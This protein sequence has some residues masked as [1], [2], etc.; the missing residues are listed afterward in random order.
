MNE[1]TKIYLIALYCI[2]GVGDK[3]I[4]S[5]IERYSSIENIFLDD[6]S[7][8][9]NI[10]KTAVARNRNYTF[11]K[12]EILDKAN[13]I[14]EDSKKRNIEIISIFDKDYPFNLK[15]IDNPPYILYVKGNK[16]VL[17]RNSISIVGTRQPQ[18]VSIDYAFEL[19]SVLSALNITVVSGF[20]KGVDTASHLG[21]LSANGN[22]IAVFGNGLDYIYPSE[23]ARIY[24]K[25]IEHS[26]IISEFPVGTMPDRSH[27]P[28]RNRIIS[29]LSYATV[30]VEAAARSGALITTNFA[31]EH[32]RDVFIAPYDETKNYFFGNHKLYKDGAIIANSAID[33]INEFDDMFSVD[34]EYI[35]MKTRYFEN[36]Q[37]NSN[38]KKTN[39]D[40]VNNS[41]IDNENIISIKTKKEEHKE[42]HKE[43]KKEYDISLLTE[44]EKSIFNTILKN[45]NIHIDDI[46]RKLNIPVNNIS[47]TLM[48]LEI[49]GVIRQNPGKCYILE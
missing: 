2:N 43:I 26:L 1:N 22:T 17:R 11:T 37:I 6:E 12:N 45:N 16:N 20:A 3:S 7:G 40:N 9:V 35:K 21:A 36:G 4:A 23:N 14:V 48:Q 28:R 34:S 29:G 24:D 41:F 46:A 38:N 44:N 13:K 47:M 25:M 10:L 18:K 42:E 33:I 32:G 49:K 8:I 27:F 39:V 15:Q 30:M 31:L 5:L 19:G